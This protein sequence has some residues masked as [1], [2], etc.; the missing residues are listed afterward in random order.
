MKSQLIFHIIM[1]EPAQP[2]D[3]RRIYDAV[4]HEEF[5]YKCVVNCFQL[6]SISD[7]IMTKYTIFYTVKTSMHGWHWF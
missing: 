4:F 3:S 2:L 7:A 6:F 1:L 5:N